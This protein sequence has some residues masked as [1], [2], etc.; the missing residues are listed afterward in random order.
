MNEQAVRKTFEDAKLIVDRFASERCAR[1][2]IRR[3]IGRQGFHP[4]V[5]DAHKMLELARFVA[6]LHRDHVRKG[7]I[8][9]IVLFG[10]ERYDPEFSVGRL[11]REDDLI[12]AEHLSL[13]Y[14]DFRLVESAALI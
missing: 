3:D 9:R 14:M 8:A 4:S 1:F 11:L 5:L 10:D 6:A 7:R 13:H 2:I 12:E